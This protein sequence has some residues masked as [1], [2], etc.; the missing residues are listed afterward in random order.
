MAELKN[1][2]GLI[3]GIRSINKD[4]WHE[5]QVGEDDEP[6]YWQRKEWVDWILEEADKAEKE[7]IREYEWFDADKE[8]PEN[9]V[10]VLVYF[11]DDID[12]EIDYC[13]TSENYGTKWFA[14]DPDRA[15]RKWKPFTKPTERI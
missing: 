14:N 13:T 5:V 12:V 10:P 11:D 7:V 15:V 2:K 1:V 8:L 6:C 4:R 9:D 3:S